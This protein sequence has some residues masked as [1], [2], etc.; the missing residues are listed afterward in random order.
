MKS[1][2]TLRGKAADVRETQDEPSHESGSEQAPASLRRAASATQNASPQVKLDLVSVAVTMTRKEQQALDRHIAAQPDAT[3]LLE[4]KDANGDAYSVAGAL[5]GLSWTMDDGT[6][7]VLTAREV[8][9]QHSRYPMAMSRAYDFA[10]E[11]IQ[12]SVDA[13][14]GAEMF[15]LRGTRAQAFDVDALQKERRVQRAA[16]LRRMAESLVAGE[17]TARGKFEALADIS[18]DVSCAFEDA[19]RA[20]APKALCELLEAHRAEVEERL[21]GEKLLGVRLRRGLW[22][23]DDDTK[24]EF[25]SIYPI[26]GENP[27]DCSYTEHIDL[28]RDMRDLGVGDEIEQ[29][30]VWLTETLS[31]GECVDLFLS[32]PTT[33]HPVVED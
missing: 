26:Y 5:G 20:L 10:V 8:E 12:A 21:G 6:S 27:E 24:A 18:D 31:V 16:G 33:V 1:G 3:Y 4:G 11:A 23:N 29:Y 32:D 17:K 28:K 15:P 19:Q 13:Q 9:V 7:G 14:S 2:L 22:D 30:A 25:P